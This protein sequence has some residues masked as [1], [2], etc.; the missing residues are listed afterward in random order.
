MLKVQTDS[1]FS[2]LD[3]ENWAGVGLFVRTQSKV[4]AEWVRIDK[5]GQEKGT[6]G[7]TKIKK[8]PVG[9]G[10]FGSFRKCL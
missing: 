10:G 8:D 3:A 4:L 2:C 1:S 6:K 9:S 7:D 5:C